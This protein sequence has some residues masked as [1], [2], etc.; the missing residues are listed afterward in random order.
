MTITTNQSPTEI[1]YNS[2]PRILVQGDRF[3]IVATRDKHALSKTGILVRYETKIST[4]IERLPAW[5]PAGERRISVRTQDD[6]EIKWLNQTILYPGEDKYPD[7]FEA[8]KVRLGKPLRYVGP[9]VEGS[10]VRYWLVNGVREDHNSVAVVRETLCT[11]SMGVEYW[12]GRHVEVTLP[13][14]ITRHDDIA[15]IS[16][17]IEMVKIWSWMCGRGLVHPG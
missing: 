4:P 17:R 10:V 12:G 3:R 7:Q 6:A 5:A 8:V 14:P 15:G 16:H 2:A 1:I 9:D 11:D 13:A